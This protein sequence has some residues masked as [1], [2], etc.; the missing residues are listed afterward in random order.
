VSA[1]GPVRPA[2]VVASVAASAVEDAVL[3]GIEEEGVPCVVERSATGAAVELA[4]SA[5]LRSPLGV[6]VGIDA[7][8]TVCVQPEKVA[9]VIPELVSAAGVAAAR[10]LGHNAARICVGLPLRLV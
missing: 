9:D 6:G 10:I 1:D 4:R 7:A 2:V 8:G 3:A 5:A